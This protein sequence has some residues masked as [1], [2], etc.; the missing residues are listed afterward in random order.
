MLRS[1]SPVGAVSF[2]ASEPAPV[3]TNVKDGR[4]SLS[5]LV[6]ASPSPAY[7]VS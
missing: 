5:S 1:L 7:E 4:P 2:P 3:Y 6:L